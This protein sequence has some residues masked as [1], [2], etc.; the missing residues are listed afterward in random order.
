MQEALAQLLNNLFRELFLP[1]NELTK[2]NL[3]AV[4]LNINTVI[5]LPLLFIAQALGICKEVD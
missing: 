4:R 2:T 3:Y 5:N 1:Q